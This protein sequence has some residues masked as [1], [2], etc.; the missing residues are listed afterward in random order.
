MKLTVRDKVILIVLGIAVLVFGVYK[1]LFVPTTVKIAEL[2]NSKAEVEALSADITPVLEQKNKLKAR[3]KELI[4][5]AN[6]IKSDDGS[7]TATNEE[8]LVFL[9]ESTAKNNVQVTGFNDLGMT[10]EDG[11]YTATF[12]FELRGLAYNI[13]NVLSEIDNLGIRTSYGSVSF[14][15]NEDYE[16]LKRYFDNITALPWYTEPEEKEEPSEEQTDEETNE[17]EVPTVEIP[18][19]TL[20]PEIPQTVPSAPSIITPVPSVPEPKQEE[21]KK[22]DRTIN[23]RLNS[24]LEQTSTK[25]NNYKV[26]FLTNTIEAPVVTI[27]SAEE[28]MLDIVPSTENDVFVPHY[29][30]REMRLAVTVKIIMFSEPQYDTSILNRSTESNEVL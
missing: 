10:E 8:F 27:P 13:N 16:Y 14:R 2:N 5:I 21:P 9:G 15:Q 25:S 20:L 7:P 11:V 12:D 24:L 19:A 4:G 29:G 1:V 3:E 26:V 30:L 23:D 17:D 6:G 22:E 28:P 18:P